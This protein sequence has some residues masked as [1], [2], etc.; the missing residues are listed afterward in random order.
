MPTSSI[1]VLIIVEQS[2]QPDPNLTISAS[3]RRFEWDL[4]RFRFTHSQQ[5]PNA[6][7]SVL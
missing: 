2:Q 6:M 3:A 4:I 1:A 7:R 5:H